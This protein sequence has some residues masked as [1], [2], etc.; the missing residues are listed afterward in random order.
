MEYFKGTQAECQAAIDRVNAALGLVEE[1]IDFPVALDAKNDIYECIIVG[2]E[3]KNALTS[4]QK[5]K[6][7]AERDDEMQR[8]VDKKQEDYINSLQL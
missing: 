4:E 1:S 7:L 6:L 3:Q 2:D 5:N 8:L